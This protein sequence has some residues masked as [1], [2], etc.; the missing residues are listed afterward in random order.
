MS[1]QPYVMT[2]GKHEGTPITRVPVSYLRWMVNNNTR[3]ADQA[4]AELERRGTTC[5]RLE[6]SGHAID[7]ASQRLLEI[8]QSKRKKGEGLHSWLVRTVE[9]ALKGGAV[10][11][12]K[13]KFRGMVFVFDR[14]TAEWPVLMTVMLNDKRNGNGK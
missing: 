13:I 6:I 8:W 1:D 4:R 2:F 9:K 11:G 10:S 5:P 12:D 7:R 3:Q 14:S